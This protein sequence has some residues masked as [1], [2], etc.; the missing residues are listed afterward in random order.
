M[1][2]HE[3]RFKHVPGPGLGDGDDAVGP[4][5]SGLHFP[6]PDFAFFT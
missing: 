5:S 3:P 4:R 6:T 2:E 1:M